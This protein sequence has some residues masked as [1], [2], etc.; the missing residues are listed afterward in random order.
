MA[1]LLPAMASAQFDFGGGATTDKPWETF[2]LN[3]KTRVK[4]DFHSGAT[5]DGIINFFENQSGV[6]IVKDP[7]LTGTT[8]LTSARAVPLSDAFQILSTTLSLKGFSLSKQGNLLVIKQN[9]QNTAPTQFDPSVLQGLGGG[10]SDTELKVYHIEYANASQVAK[11]LDDVYAPAATGGFNF[12][13]GGFGGGNRGF[14]GG[15]PGGFNLSALAGRNQPQVK[16]SSDDFSNDVIV[17]AP[18]SEQVQIATLIKQL[19][20]QNDLP[21]HTKVYHLQ[22]AAASDTANVV[23]NVLTS[24]VPR[25][26]GG[27]TT[28]QTQGPAAFFNAIRGQTA[29]SG[30]VVADTRTNS[31][32]VTATDDDLKIVDQVVTDLDHPVTL[33]STTFVFPLQNARAETVA[34]LL[35]SA[36]GNKQGVTAPNASQTAQFNTTIG[37]ASTGTQ[38]SVTNSPNSSTRTGT[39]LQGMLPDDQTEQYAM[40]PTNA[41]DAAL[42]KLGLNYNPFP[43]QEQQAAMR[44]AGQQ[45][46]PIQLE[47]PAADS[48][49]LMTNIGVSAGAGQGFGG[50]FRQQSNQQNT[51]GQ[52]TTNVSRNAQGQIVPTI[53]P[54]GGVTIIPDYNTNSV[55]VVTNPD[56]ADIVRKMLVQ[57]D[58]IPRQVMI[59][60]IIVEASLDK[61]SKLGVEWTF[62]HSLAA[63]LGSG[64]S[65]TAATN[66]G[67]QSGTTATGSLP[68]FTYTISSKN[69]NAFL[70]AINT[71]TKFQVLSTPRIMTTN[72]VQAQINVS[73]SIPYITS[74]Q[75]DSAG[76]PTY[77]YSFLN[78]GVILTI[79][80]RILS[81]GYV[82]LDV[83]Q[84][85][86]ELQ[87]YQNIGNTQ[88]P[89]VNQR[90]AQSTVS[91]MDG[92]TVILGGI[93]SKQVT[94]TVNK[95]PLLGDIPLL[96]NLFKST[97]KDTT[98]T[99]LLV[100]MTPH[101]INDPTDAKKL[102]GDTIKEMEPDDQKALKDFKKNGNNGPTV[103]GTATPGTGS[104]TQGNGGKS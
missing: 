93:I 100:F 16:A 14:G 41:E 97:S 80:P 60:T 15:N 76:N 46:L 11:V 20:I 59:Q 79:Q 8:S 26:R 65:G 36:F 62:G 72:N 12:Q 47:D 40:Q 73:Q 31:L 30:Q 61:S 29:G 39:G 68:G 94:S 25:G 24:N 4:L 21:Q 104:G 57:L 102:T 91:V 67:V 98:K 99:E 10:Q 78:V 6:T 86:N 66:F 83:D 87:G 56:N 70:D 52:I 90:E 3:S 32:V 18:A 71:D 51:S 81:N 19:D 74:V 5:W 53:D 2:H 27:A 37:A 7:A 43:S 75:S 1:A 42:R 17:N 92:E 50:I 89:V 95:I 23:Q 69:L 35:Q 82:T 54:T 44:S 38:R 9:K 85:A 84:S 45:Y 58:Q 88:A 34:N 22:Y 101:V 63:L 96:G 77:S 103:P 55:I 64:A 28:S 49:E 33:Q 48:G 13:Q